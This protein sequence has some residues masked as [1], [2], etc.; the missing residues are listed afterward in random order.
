MTVTNLFL[1][2]GMAGGPVAVANVED[3][4]S[5]TQCLFLL[6][7]RCKM[8]NVLMLTEN[9]D[10]F[11]LPMKSWCMRSERRILS[12]WGHSNESPKSDF[13]FIDLKIKY[14]RIFKQS[15]FFSWTFEIFVLKFLK[16]SKYHSTCWQNFKN[17]K[18]KI[19]KF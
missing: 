15:Y 11:L 16:K 10:L 6:K 1:F 3:D 2:I 5:T 12:N 17:F 8:R 4:E 18:T 9:I 19:S 7:K 14:L 13:L